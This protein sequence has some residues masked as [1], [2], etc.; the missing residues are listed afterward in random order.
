MSPV[1]V[2]LGPPTD[3]WRKF[4]QQFDI[5]SRLLSLNRSG[6]E[7][8]KK[9]QSYQG[10]FWPIEGIAKITVW[11]VPSGPIFYFSGK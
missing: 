4:G 2:I 9:T 6:C 7:L 11:A 3:S 1:E 10:G 5:I 8:E